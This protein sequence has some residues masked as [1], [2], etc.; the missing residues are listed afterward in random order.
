MA[1]SPDVPAMPDFH[2]VSRASGRHPDDSGEVT[3]EGGLLVVEFRY[4]PDRVA[5]IKRMAGAKF[6][7][8]TKRWTLPVRS[9]ETLLR[10]RYFHPEALRYAVSPELLGE[11]IRGEG[12]SVSEAEARWSQNPFAVS[13]RDIAL[14]ALD[15]VF[16]FHEASSTLRAVPAFR[17]KARALLERLPGGHY[18]KSDKGYYVPAHLFPELLK[19]LRDRGLRF[20]VEERCG[21]RLRRTA[22]LRT[23]IVH[24][25]HQPAAEELLE[26]S[27]R[28][29][30]VLCAPDRFS[31]FVASTEQLR[32]LLPDAASFR[33]RRAQ[34]QQLSL[35]ELRAVLERAAFAGVRCWFERS[36]GEIVDRARGAAM[37]LIE[38]SPD[39]FDDGL[40]AL[41]IPDRCLAL[42]AQ[43]RPAV[44][45]RESEAQRFRRILQRLTGEGV[46]AAPEM[47][48]SGYQAIECVPSLLPAFLDALDRE[49]EEGT[50][51]IPR[52]RRFVQLCD[53]VTQ[54]AAARQR[55][56]RFRGLSDAAFD[57]SAFGLP[58][59]AV[60]LFPHQRVGVSWLT[61]TP[62]AFLADDMGLG[63][64]LTVLAAF[65]LLR[66]RGDADTLLV[67]CPNSLTRNWLREVAQWI[68]HC[69][70][71]L[72]QGDRGEKVQSLKKLRWGGLP[73]QVLILNYEAA[74]LE[75]LLPELTSLLAER[76]TMLC[77]D[78]SQRVKNPLSKTY[79]SLLEIAALCER[80]VLLSGTPTPRDLTD[81]WAQMRVLDDGL[82]FGTRYYEWLQSVAELGTRFSE[83]AVRRFKPGAVGDTIARVE[84]V[85]LRRKK[86][87][88]IDLPEKTFLIRDVELTGDQR[89]R[90]EEV[91]K[92][93]LLRVTSLN[94]KSFIREI[95]NVL[96]EYLRAVQIASNPRL[97]DESWKGE[98]AK[99][100]E[101]DQLVEEIAGEREEKLVVWTNYLG[102]VRELVKRYEAYGA[103]AFSGEVSA[104]VRALTV[105]EFQ[106]QR[107]IRVLV[108]VPAAGGV[109]ITLTA[110]QT[111]V[112]LDK[113][114]NAEHWL[115]SVDR[116]HRIGQQGTVRIISLHGCGVD[117]LISRNI[118][119]KMREQAR[120][121][122]DDGGTLLSS[123]ELL[124]SHDELVAAVERCRDSAS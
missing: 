106:Q 83:F 99:F 114:W 56:V 113:T 120:V 89:K 34:A 55:T 43:G 12:G 47:R 23:A 93:L 72:L 25:G 82:R 98:P 73:F 67:V 6:D 22:A 1:E 36:A 108:A 28:P 86:E 71:L 116:I 13:D 87:D 84:E 39:G 40:L 79:T 50:P 81:I 37:L 111:A 63:K 19:D 123:D 61:E 2:P 121:L 94:G 58:D 60:K 75:Y 88:V 90:Y 96:E 101:L 8:A 103:R 97:V 118:A 38:E 92:E 24:E 18:I 14:L 102:N 80:R 45:V 51:A 74:R 115:Q 54:Q 7:R 29:A 66:Q 59:F 46:R 35:P 26:S 42:S 48:A 3:L 11:L 107:A 21:E 20:A 52:S 110:A 64:T 27:L 77:L 33:E 16:R 10:S 44:I 32:L 15:V 119:R 49:R 109:G 57:P 53:A 30:I 78:E 122:G 65:D 62:R 104:E 100:R 69:R 85:M 5:E 31:L 76:R 17:S 117:E 68:P 41:A 95:T 9:Y 4:S 105:E 124:P 70:G 112:Y 91:R